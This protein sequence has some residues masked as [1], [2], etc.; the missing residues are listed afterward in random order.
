MAAILNRIGLGGNKAPASPPEREAIRALPANWYTSPEMFELERRAI[1]SRKWLL[2]THSLRLKNAGD[3]LR[4]Q[5]AGFDIVLSRDRQ[6]NITAFHNVCRHRAYPVI[7]QD[8]GTAKIFSCRYHGWSYGLNGKLA[9]APGYQDIP[10]F[11]KQQNGLF[12]IH[13]RT[14]VNGFVWINLD[15]QEEPE[16]PWESDF[17]GVDVQDRLESFDF[18]NYE[19]DHTWKIDAEYNWKIAADNYNE[20][21]H[22]AT[23]HPDVPAVANLETYDVTPKDK[24][25][26]HEASASEEQKKNGMHIVS[27][28]YWPYASMTVSPHFFFMQKFMPSST[29]T[30]NIYYEVFRNRHSSEEDFQEVNQ[31]FKRIMS[32]DKGLC[33]LAQKNLNAGVFVN[34][35]L[36]PHMEKGPLYFQ[37]MCREEV[38]NWHKREQVAKRE[39]WP[40]RQ[41]LPDSASEANE[42]VD[43]CNGLSCSENN[44]VLAW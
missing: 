1:F 26:D 34:G 39:I 15:A 23:T 18:G 33:K 25:I 14:D 43:F 8:Q 21:Y 32:E 13:V 20:C 11:D 44:E 29:T 12:K 35:E 9:K 30:T 4:Y 19:F 22:C 3:F 38:V 42:D 2:I 17:G 31:M 5:I 40:A 7:E 6:G 28:Y 27:T 37:K 41:K 10:G 16:V 36:H 24:H